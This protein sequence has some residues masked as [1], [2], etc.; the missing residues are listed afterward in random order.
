M[1]G[2][3][4]HYLKATNARIKN[5]ILHVLTYKWE[6]NYENTWLHTGEQ[7]ILG[8]FRGWEDREDQ[9]K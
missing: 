1:D 8:H 9:E 6:L 5:Q 3:R 2:A 4:F 7:H